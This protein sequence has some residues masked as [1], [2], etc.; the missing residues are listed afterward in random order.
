MSVAGQWDEVNGEVLRSRCSHAVYRRRKLNIKQSINHHRSY[1]DTQIHRQ[2][3]RHTRQID[4]KLH[5]LN[6]CCICNQSPTSRTTPVYPPA[7][8]VVSYQT[9]GSGH[10]AVTHD[11]AITGF[12]MRNIVGNIVEMETNASS[13]RP[14]GTRNWIVKASCPVH[15]ASSMTKPLMHLNTSSARFR[16]H[17]IVISSVMSW[18]SSS[19]MVTCRISY[20]KHSLSTLR[21]AAMMACLDVRSDAVFDTESS[22]TK[23]NTTW[24]SD[25]LEWRVM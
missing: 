18:T 11:L 19:G 13:D 3:M 15:K 2:R 10:C 23:W 16:H 5:Q 6:D 21:H 1:S 17:C 8:C 25:R 7:A 20:R 9:T 14:F 4:I 12:D 22:L 24:T